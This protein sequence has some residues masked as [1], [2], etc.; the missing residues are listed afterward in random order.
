MTDNSS[1][2]LA[3]R[4]A[5]QVAQQNNKKILVITAG[6]AQS[7]EVQ[8]QLD[9]FLKPGK[10]SG[11]NS[12][13]S[14]GGNPEESPAE[15]L[16]KTSENNSQQPDESA[17]L[18]IPDNEN[19][20][21]DSFSPGKMLA[22]K[23]IKSIYRMLSGEYQILLIG[24]NTLIRLLAPRSYFLG[25]GLAIKTGQTLDY[26]A[27][28]EQLINNGYIKC[29]FVRQPGEMAVRGAIMDM[30]PAASP[31]P[32]RIEL[33]DDTVVSLRSFS[34]EE[35]TSIETVSSIN[36]L[37]S[38]EYPVSED[39]RQCFCRSWQRFFSGEARLH[40]TY[41]EI[42]QGLIPQGIES[43][44]PFFFEADESEDKPSG[45]N[46]DKTPGKTPD[47]TLGKTLGRTLESYFDYLSASIESHQVFYAKEIFNNAQQLIDDAKLRYE[48]L[49]GESAVL[50]PPDFLYL[51]VEQLKSHLK[52]QPNL[53]ENPQKNQKLEIIDLP[54][55]RAQMESDIKLENLVK[56]RKQYS[57][58]ILICAFSM[59]R[60]ELLKSWLEQ[61]KINY[62]VFSDWN[63]F[64]NS[65]KVKGTTTVG[66]MFAD[67]ADGI[68]HAEWAIITENNIFNESIHQSSEVKSSTAA[69]APQSNLLIKNIAHIAPGEL[70]VH[71][72]HGVGKFLGLE[73][74]T[75]QDYCSEYI[76]IE[77]AEQTKLYLPVHNLHL[78]SRYIG[79]G[80]RQHSLDKLGSKQ[81]SIRKANAMRKIED[82]AASLL[83][84]Y[85]KRANRKG[86]TF[87][88][89]TNE[90]EEFSAGFPYAET[91]DQLKAINDVLKDMLAEKKTDRLVCGD[92]GFG[93]TEVAMR[94]AYIAAASGYQVALLVPT[95]ILAGQHLQTFSNRF[96]NTPFMI[97]QLT[98]LSG[99]KN[100]KQI[101][102]DIAKGKA[103]IIIG[104]HALLSKNMAFKNLG[105]VIIDEEHRFGVRQK[106]KL[107]SLREDV[108]I[109]SLTAT[110][111]PRTLNLALSGL[112]DISLM[113]SPPPGR[114]PI[115]TYVGT[116]SD[117]IIKESI[118]RELMRDGQV[119]YVYNNIA[120]IQ[121]KA[122]SLGKLFPDVRSAIL[123]GS[124]D[125]WQLEETMHDFYHKK[126]AILVSTTIIENGL[127]VPDANTIIIEKAENF[128]LAQLHQM[129]G[130]V[131]RRKRQAFAYFL[132]SN[133]SGIKSKAA[134]RIKAVGDSSLPGLG[135]NLA[136]NDLEIRGAG[137]ILGT[138]Q[139]GSIQKIGLELY[140]QM[141]EKTVL[142]LQRKQ[143]QKQQKPS[144]EHKDSNNAFVH[145]AR[146]AGTS[147]NN[148]RNASPSLNTAPLAPVLPEINSE[149]DITVS[150]L[151]PDDYIDDVYERLITYKRMA[152]GNETTLNAIR[153]ELKDK[154]GELPPY[155]ANL[156]EIHHI[157]IM[158]QQLGITKLTLAR[159]IG[160]ALI[161]KEFPQTINRCR[162]LMEEDPHN[163]GF[164]MEGARDGAGTGIGSGAENGS[165]HFRCSGTDDAKQLSEVNR[166][167][168][169]IQDSL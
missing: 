73:Q 11:G 74:I 27:F 97:K 164:K 13:E 146:S 52:G 93:K 24:I 90:Y 18:L 156:F 161:S 115:K 81:W 25:R 150:A 58:K 157:R 129:R 71:A 153:K 26:Q 121:Q 39:A 135:F 89:P 105:L 114:L 138:E 6:A 137:E 102:E 19:L 3:Y 104:T 85:A 32:Y 119:Y 116:H 2:N 95:T 65:E 57:G 40:S 1:S 66:L 109:L 48:T 49:G 127:D 148:A 111:I 147:P 130:R 59:R 63:S 133:E 167:L 139:S 68:C 107:K 128:G 43:F 169:A 163:Y 51:S 152:T 136:A 23:R 53:Y 140:T 122:D 15:S 158:A 36:I 46:S 88:P 14:S 20:P 100:V 37:P 154:Y 92:V 54:D 30:F 110:P 67:I 151:L 41:K 55:L 72:E 94:A 7:Y 134:K 117:E 44:L 31:L 28:S 91:E 29:N 118:T 96:A 143:K 16:E 113:A 106:E 76:S 12:G 160:K 78:L 50:L 83:E 80:E 162:E 69:F 8:R 124:M 61:A 123:H 5:S 70:V 34:V 10:K 84:L 112:R 17:A 125:K 132:I 79:R 22:S 38:T 101:K 145:S 144:T 149:I 75:H 108:D 21:Y 141:L 98:R 86:I 166:I 99:S 142:S 126:I 82:S 47:K 42:K 9:F 131:G 64:I 165:L 155:A 60:K 159:T 77:Y 168:I 45:T 103:D 56:F 62:A 35:Q 33:L 4:V 120:A 87:M